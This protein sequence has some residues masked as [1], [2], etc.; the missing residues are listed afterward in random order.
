MGPDN[1]GANESRV[2]KFKSRFLWMDI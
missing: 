2:I 1:G